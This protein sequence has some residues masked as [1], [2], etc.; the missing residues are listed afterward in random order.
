[1]TGLCCHRIAES[2]GG[3]GGASV[4]IET[5]AQGSDLFTF[6]AVDLSRDNHTRPKDSGHM[7]SSRSCNAI[8][9]LSGRTEGRVFPT[10]PGRCEE[11]E[12]LTSRTLAR[13]NPGTSKTTQVSQCTA[14]SARTKG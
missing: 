9:F 10:S 13:R 11:D 4:E 3:L 8:T 1:M 6:A 14:K 2:L 7:L 12:A 5:G